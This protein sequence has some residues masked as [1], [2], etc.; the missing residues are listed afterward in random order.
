MIPAIVA[1]VALGLV[2]GQVQGATQVGIK[3]LLDLKKYPDARCL[4][5]T[6]GGFHIFSNGTSSSKWYIHHSG[7]G[8]C[9][10]R[11]VDSQQSTV[12]SCHHRFSTR[13][14]SSSEEFYPSVIQDFNAGGDYGS[15]DP[16]RNPMMHDWNKVQLIYCDGGSFSGRNQTTTTVAGKELHFKGNFILEAVIAT[17]KE[18]YGLGSASDVVIS[19]GSA[20]GLATYLH[21]DQWRNSLPPSTF[22]VAMPDGG[23]FLDWNASKPAESAHSYAYELRAIFHDFNAS[24]NQECM[25]EVKASGIDES[26]CMLAEHTVAFIQT[27]LFAL[28]SVVDQWQLENELGSKD[29]ES[30]NEYR[31]ATT[32]RILT[33]FGNRFDRGG[34]IDSCVHHCGMWDELFI[35]GVRMAD[36]FSSWYDAQHTAWIHK[37]APR[38]QRFWWQAKAFPCKDCCGNGLLYVESPIVDNIFTSLS[39]DSLKETNFVI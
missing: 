28:Q 3:H 24:V 14:G 12:D 6:P 20:G 34:F 33:A 31:E 2:C 9:S 8:W 27:P 25:M 1:A 23:F 26:I 11:V 17:L 5:G 10:Q 37:V 36:A 16:S 29:V 38:G 21:V 4:D 7:G 35:D 19:G 13:L 22:V 15:G 39:A 30:T 32:S 18:E